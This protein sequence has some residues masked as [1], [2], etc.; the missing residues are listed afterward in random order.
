M[1]VLHTPHTVVQSLAHVDISLVFCSLLSMLVF[2]FVFFM[3][4]MKYLL[5]IKLS[6]ELSNEF[7]LAVSWLF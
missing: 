4:Y 7:L 3:K 6:S 1:F 2:L 5:S